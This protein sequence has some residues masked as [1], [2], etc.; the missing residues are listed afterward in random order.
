MNVGKDQGGVPIQLWRNHRSFKG[1]ID[2]KNEFFS[3]RNE[4][5]A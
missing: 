5:I 2:G 3:Q 1:I 4:L